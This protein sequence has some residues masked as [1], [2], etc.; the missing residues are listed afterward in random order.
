M[1]TERH[2]R[3]ATPP[4]DVKL[5][6]DEGRLANI[7]QTGALVHTNSKLLVGRERPLTLNFE[8]AL[9]VGPMQVQIVRV[10]FLPPKAQAPNDPRKYGV[11]VTFTTEL[12]GDALK[13]VNNLCGE[14]FHAKE[15]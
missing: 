6:T 13:A 14:A 4:I 5:A 9:P 7:S 15:Q 10:E 8:N 1:S 2:I 12:S 11:A 3:V